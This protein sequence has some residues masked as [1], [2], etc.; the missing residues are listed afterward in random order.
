[1]RPTRGA[2]CKPRQGAGRG[3]VQGVHA[4]RGA[5]GLP[6]LGE[7][8]AAAGPPMVAGVEDEIRVVA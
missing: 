6:A 2:R 8:A 3:P 5:P 7:P 1:M 4:T